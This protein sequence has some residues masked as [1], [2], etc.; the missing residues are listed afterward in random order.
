LKPDLD[1]IG[2]TISMGMPAVFINL[3]AARSQHSSSRKYAQLGLKLRKC[4]YNVDHPKFQDRGGRMSLMVNPKSPGR[5][6]EVSD[7][8]IKNKSNW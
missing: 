2:L 5:Q 1:G 4:W 8:E 7:I 6:F 3:S